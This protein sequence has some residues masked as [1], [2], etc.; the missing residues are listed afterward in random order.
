M[1]EKKLAGKRGNFY[2][3]KGILLNKVKKEWVI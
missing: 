2:K 3:S 1:K